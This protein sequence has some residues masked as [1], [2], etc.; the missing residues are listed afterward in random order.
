MIHSI[1][2]FFAFAKVSMLSQM[3][4][5]WIYVV[6]MLGK[7][8]T[9][10]SS[11]VVLAIMMYRFET[12]GEWSAYEVL[13]LYALNTLTYAIGSTFAMPING[14]GARIE[15]GLFDSM[16][17]KPVNTMYLA[18]CKQASAGYVSNYALG[19]GVMVFAGVR[20]GLEVTAASIILLIFSIIGG[21]L[22]H[23]AAHI[24]IG[25][26]SFWTIRGN[27]FSMIISNAF[28]FANY[29]ISIYRPA[30]QFVL[31]FILP[32]AFITFY[33]A[34]LFLDKTNE[35]IFHPAIYYLSPVVGLICFAAAY[36]FWKRGINAYQSTGS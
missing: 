36:L 11:F 9:F 18:L 10:G 22:I 31:T 12:L 13:F 4:Y 14:I 23:M 25:T 34:G 27:A 19:I 32:V 30:I 21:V 17:T 28:T 3:E 33:P 5:R 15:S 8:C 7:I 1:R 26:I 35:S 2:L 16:L 24:A 20:M 6:R 29:P